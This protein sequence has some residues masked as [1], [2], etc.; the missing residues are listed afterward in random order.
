MSSLDTV[1]DTSLQ[2]QVNALNWVHTIDLG[3]G[4]VTPGRWP[5]H[6]LILRAFDT[7]DFKGKKILDIGCW[8]G[9]W[10]FEA[11]KRGAAEVYATDYVSQRSYHEQPTFLLAH[12]ALNSRVKYHPNLPVFD[13]KRLGEQFDIVL[14]CGVYYHLKNPLLALARL[15]EVMK[16]GAILVVEGPVIAAT[17]E[18]LARFY[19]HKWFVNDPSNW[20]VP[21]VP[22]LQQ[23]V[24]CS[25]FEI[26]NEYSDFAPPRF[27]LV[28]SLKRWLRG[29]LGRSSESISRHVL[30]A[31]AV[32]RAD[33]NYIFPDD[34]LASCDLNHYGSASA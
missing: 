25:F 30:T 13:V 7:I 22:C 4:V 5:P 12:Q 8:D 19:Y 32:C 31:Q 29:V 6:P 24:E 3:N 9:L 17:E 21:T 27:S 28:G 15:R 33:P 11:E 1:S 2:N 20:W 23:W 26:R 14:F 34:D 18:I 16:P 10:S